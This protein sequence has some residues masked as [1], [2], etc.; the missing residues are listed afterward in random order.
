[1]EG[2]SA[3]TARWEDA[4]PLSASQLATLDTPALR[5]IRAPPPQASTAGAAGAAAATDPSSAAAASRQGA[6]ASPSRGSSDSD[7]SSE[8]DSEEEEEVW[9]ASEII[10]GVWVGRKEDAELPASL[11]EHGIGLVVS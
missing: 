7:C 1:M 5:R 3:D 2:G 4:P 8:D 10:P 11:A 6:A 9:G